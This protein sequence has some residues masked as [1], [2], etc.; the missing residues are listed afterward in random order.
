MIFFLVVLIYAIGIR[1]GT[2]KIFEKRGIAGWK[3]FVPVLC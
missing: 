1:V 3:A 2:Y